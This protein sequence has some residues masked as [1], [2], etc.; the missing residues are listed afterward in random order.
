[1]ASFE[2]LKSDLNQTWFIDIICEPSYDKVRDLT[3]ILLPKVW[4]KKKKTKQNK[5]QIQNLG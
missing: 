2:K 1:M 4:T 5:K 3:T